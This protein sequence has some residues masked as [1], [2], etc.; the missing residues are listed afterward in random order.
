MWKCA[1]QVRSRTL[2]KKTLCERFPRNPYTATNIDVWEMDLADLCSLSKYDKYKY[3]FNIIDIF[4]VCLERASKTK[5]RYLNHISFEIYFKIENQLP[6][7]QTSVLNFLIK[8]QKHLK[9]QGV[10]FHTTQNPDIKD[11]IERFNKSLKTRMYKYFTKY[12][13][14]LIGRHK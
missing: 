9:S 13:I 2:Q 12:N 11:V 5:D 3:L 1:C 7:N 4:A 6:H 14:R 10:N 8:V